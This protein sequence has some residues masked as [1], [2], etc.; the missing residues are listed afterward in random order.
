MGRRV[1]PTA[2]EGQR[3]SVDKVCFTDALKKLSIFVVPPKA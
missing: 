1:L 2:K 3:K